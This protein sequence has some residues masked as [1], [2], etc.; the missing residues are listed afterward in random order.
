MKSMVQQQLVDKAAGRVRRTTWPTNPAIALWS[1]AV[2]KKIVM[3][4]TGVILVGFVIAHMLGNLKIFLGEEAIDRY[5]VFLREVGEPLFPYEVLLWIARIILLISVGLHI[6]AAVEL[7]LMNW[8]ARPRNYQAKE[9]VASTYASRTM[10]YSGVIVGLFIVYHLLHFTVGLVGFKPDQ[11]QH[12][13][14]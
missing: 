3:A 9:S 11:Y 14:V 12:L 10:R 7:T 13:K 8:A 1:T 5:A 6:I 4:V 2:G